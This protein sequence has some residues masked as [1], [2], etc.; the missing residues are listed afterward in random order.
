MN[1]TTLG[2]LLLWASFSPT[3]DAKVKLA[4]TAATEYSQRG[5]TLTAYDP[6]VQ[7]LLEYEFDN[8]LF[9]GLWAGNVQFGQTGDDDYEL[10][11]FL[12]YGRRLTTDFAFDVTFIR[13]TF[14]GQNQP[15]DY[16]WKELM[17]SAYL[18][19]RW[20]LSAGVAENWLATNARTNVAELG[21]RFPLPY[22]L[23]ADATVGL[24]LLPAPYRD[25][26]YG[27]LGL[28]RPLGPIDVR[29]AYIATDSD[30]ANWFN[31]LAKSRWIAAISYAL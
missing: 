1:R 4:V 7:G 15:R 10:D 19:D 29:V 9:A 23:S 22:N 17:V 28:S 13:Y 16:D 24:Q 11:F 20:L 8:G 14:P 27:E 30:A 21:Y 5:V 25:Y 6:S 3:V 26:V 12:G 31:R 2:I 18:G